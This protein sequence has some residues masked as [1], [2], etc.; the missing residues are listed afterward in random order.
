MSSHPFLRIFPILPILASSAFLLLGPAPLSATDAQEPAAPAAPARA[1]ALLRD[2]HRI[3]FLGDSITQAG[4]YV[5]DCDCW[6]LAHGFQ[7]E[8]LN[9]GLGSETASDLTPEENAPHLKRFGFGR[10]FL[11]ERLDRALAATKPDLLFA[12][13]G[14]N[15]AGSLP[16]DESGT[17]RFAESI[18]RMR[19]A[20]AKAGVKQIVICTPPVHDGKGD[21]ARQYFDDNL[22]RYSAW[23]L[24]KRADGWDVVDIHT[25]MLRALDDGRAKNPAFQFAADGVH[26]GREGH[27][28]MARAILTQ[29]FDANLDG[30]TS[31]EAF[32]PAH[33]REIRKLVQERMVILFEAWMTQIGHKRPGVPG[34]SGAKPGLPISEANV[35]AAEIAKRI[36]QEM[37]VSKN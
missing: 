17:R 33:G 29:C 18:T 8:V 4:D 6:L 5:T 24:S 23:L 34:A 3:V 9:L 20:A 15:D 26:P 37:V 2:V 31:A 36:A 30:V 35:K 16:P 14:M 22:S 7:I 27:W 1:A 25:P 12:C 13:Y 28:L 21:K 10:P 32:F 19:D 11:S